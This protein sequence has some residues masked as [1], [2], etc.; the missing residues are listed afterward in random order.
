MKNLHSVITRRSSDNQPSYA[1]CSPD[2]ARR[3]SVTSPV[4]FGKSP[5]DVGRGRAFAAA[6][7]A[8][9]GSLP[10][11]YR[12]IAEHATEISPSSDFENFCAAQNFE[13]RMTTLRRSLSGDQRSYA[14][15]LAGETG[16]L[17]YT[18]VQWQNF[19]FWVIFTRYSPVPAYVRRVLTNLI[20]LN[21]LQYSTSNSYIT[22]QF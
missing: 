22:L 11:H 19:Q 2:Q 18:N 10:V 20:Y 4:F 8:G 16:E 17:R 13:R 3:S 7:A 14:G 21:S 12:A 15:I 6:T 1:R 9:N 5:E